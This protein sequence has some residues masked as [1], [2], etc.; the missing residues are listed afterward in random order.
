MI[1]ELWHESDP[2]YLIFPVAPNEIS[3]AELFRGRYG[4]LLV[5]PPGE[6]DAVYVRDGEMWRRKPDKQSNVA[7]NGSDPEWYL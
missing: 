3:N 5:L 2:R 1:L 6:P 4:R 7:S